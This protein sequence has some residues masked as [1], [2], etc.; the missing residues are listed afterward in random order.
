MRERILGFQQIGN[1][2]QLVS[3]VLADGDMDPIGAGFVV[4][5]DDLM[6]AAV[7]EDKLKVL[8]TF[9]MDGR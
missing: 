4:F 5:P 6:E 3:A 7:F 2:L 9:S 8:T 1:I